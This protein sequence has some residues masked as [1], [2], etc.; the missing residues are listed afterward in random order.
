VSFVSQE[1]NGDE[2]RTL[3]IAH[4]LGPDPQQD[5]LTGTAQAWGDGAD[6]GCRHLIDVVGTPS[7]E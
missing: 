6:S 4:E 3:L 2:A 7:W 1:W 5:R